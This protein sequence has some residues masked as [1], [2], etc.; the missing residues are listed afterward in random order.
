M[1]PLSR[2][3]VTSSEKAGNG[4][5]FARL[6][7]LIGMVM[8]TGWIA[9]PAV[10]QVVERYSVSVRCTADGGEA[11]IVFGGNWNDQC[12]PQNAELTVSGDRIDVRVYRRP[13]QPCGE[14]PTPWCDVLGTGVI[15]E[16]TYRVFTQ[17]VP[18]EPVEREPITVSC[19]AIDPCDPVEIGPFNEWNLIYDMTTWD[20]DEK[21][22]QR[23]VLVAAGLLPEIGGVGASVGTWDG[24]VW[25]PLAGDIGRVDSLCVHRGALIAGASEGGPVARSSVVRWN[26]TQWEPLG[27]PFLGSRSPVISDII[28]FG[29]ELIVLGAFTTC[30]DETVIGVARWDGTAWR[31]MGSGLGGV[32]ANGYPITAVAFE[33]ELIV[34]GSFLS[35]GDSPAR[36][37]ARW[38]GVE[39]RAMDAGVP[40]AQP[41][42]TLCIHDGV[43]L[44]GTNSLDTGTI[45]AWNGASWTSGYADVAPGPVGLLLSHAD[46]LVAAPSRRYFINFCEL[47]MVK[48]WDGDTWS[49][50]AAPDGSVFSMIAWS[51]SLHIAGSFSHVGATPM[52]SVVRLDCSRSLCAADFNASGAVSSDDFFAFIEA[53]FA[54]VPRA[55]F[56]GDSRINSH[57][58]FD[59]LAAFFSGC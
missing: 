54:N 30:G 13:P 23:E 51:G 40:K 37:V 58:F 5:D 46:K 41:V 52:T 16:G 4:I 12:T 36:Y 9:P 57:D 44:A 2:Q 7:F 49:P 38:D 34:G 47:Q 27:A 17:I 15:S 25:T 11:T 31:A 19:A 59:F 35:T 42:A 14:G 28:V 48:Q 18:D 6:S 21:G 1:N 20:P 39:W 32:T 56:N 33:K 55:D 24:K 43:L 22:P 26:G 45:L 8:A 3:R 50:L 29:E 53:F 10:A